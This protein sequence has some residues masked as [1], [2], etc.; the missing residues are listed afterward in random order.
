M[1]FILDWWILRVHP[2]FHDAH[3]CNSVFC[4]V[5]SATS[6]LLSISNA[7]TNFLILNCLVLMQAAAQFFYQSFFTRNKTHLMNL[8][9]GYFP[10]IAPIEWMRR[11][12]ERCSYRHSVPEWMKVCE[13]FQFFGGTNV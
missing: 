7:A 8:V 1:I 12:V 5:Q 11:D 3:A 9:V 10:C 6:H 13:F 2:T 4:S